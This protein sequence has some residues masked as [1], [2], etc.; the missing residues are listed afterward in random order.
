QPI[1]TN[2]WTNTIDNIK[3]HSRVDS[4]PA[5]SLD[6]TFLVKWNGVDTSSGVRGYSIYYSTNG[7]FYKPWLLNTSDTAAM[8]HGR[9]DSTYKFFSIATDSALNVEAPPLTHDAITTVHIC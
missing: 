3:P 7:G 5:I 9:P 4:L 2:T 1:G 6:S 8:F